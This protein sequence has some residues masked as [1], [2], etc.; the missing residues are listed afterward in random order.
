MAVGE[1]SKLFGL[2]ERLWIG[3]TKLNHM[4]LPCQYLKN[5]DFIANT[6]LLFVFLAEYF[7]FKDMNLLPFFPV[8]DERS[9][10][11]LIRNLAKLFLLIAKIRKSE[12]FL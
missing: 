6:T 8:K 2:E 10:S 3:D 11:E 7:F 1:G 4:V 12:N 5:I 9:I